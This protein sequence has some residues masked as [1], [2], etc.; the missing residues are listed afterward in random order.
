VLEFLAESFP[1]VGAEAWAERMSRGEVVD[2]EGRPL[3]PSSP[4][5]AGGCVFY[6]REAEAEGRIP[7]E[8]RVLHRDEHLLVADKPHFRPLPARDAAR[9]PEAGG[10]ARIAR[11]APP[12]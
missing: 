3:Q 5:R 12:H 10:R 8:E 6:Y 9:P 7:F 2:E 11:P 4:Y 1:R